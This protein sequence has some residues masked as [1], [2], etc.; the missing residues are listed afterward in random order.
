M[1]RE[2]RHRTQMR[3][4]L[5]CEA[6]GVQPGTGVGWLRGLRTGGERGGVDEPLEYRSGASVELRPG[7]DPGPGG[8]AGRFHPFIASVVIKAPCTWVHHPPATRQKFILKKMQNRAALKCN[9][10]KSQFGVFN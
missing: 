6:F 8:G 2:F 9:R 10:K 4:M 7:V 3:Q 5:Q 1:T